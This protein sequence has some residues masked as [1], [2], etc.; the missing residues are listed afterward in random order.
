[1]EKREATGYILGISCFYHDAAAC[2][3][4]DGEIIA[5]AS[6]ERFTRVKHDE[7]F[8]EKA[9]QFCLDF[10]G[11]KQQD[12]DYVCF[13]E[14]PILK[15]ERL[16]E[17]YIKV[18][19]RGLM[20][21]LSAM[22]M[23]LSKKLWI[24]NIFREKMKD[25][26][27]DI[28][29]VPHHL[30]HA[31]AAYYKSGFDDAAVVTL[32]AVGE[33]STTTIGRGVGNKLKI[34][35]E[36]IFPDSLGLFYSA[37]TYYLGFKVN[38]AE[39][40]VMGLA[41]YGKPIYVDKIKELIEIFED[42]SFKL[43]MDYFAYEYDLVMINEKKFKEHFGY[44]TRKD[45]EQLEQFHKDVAASLQKVTEEIVLKIV[46]YAHGLYKT[47]NLCLSGGVALN[48]VANGR[49]IR[50]SKF[51]HLFIF[52][53]AGDAGGA[54]G[55]ALYLY[56][57][58]L[59]NEDNKK[60]KNVYVGPAFRNEDIRKFL[61][62][63]E[64]KYGEYNGEELHK[65]VA[66]KLADNRVIGLFQGR[67]EFGPR[68]LGNRSIIADPRVKENWQRV[69]LKIK[70]RE[71]FRPFAPTVMADHLESMFEIDRETPYML[72][73]AQVIVDYLPAV[74]HLDNSARI[75]SVSKEQNESYYKIIEEFYKLTGCPVIINTSFNLRGE[76][77][78][79]SH[80]D[81]FKGFLRTDMDVLVLNN[82]VI[83][84]TENDKEK[85]KER[86]TFEQ[87]G[88]D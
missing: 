75:Q 7:N 52:P 51:K 14:K 33:W 48:C 36:M 15:F 31:A 57:H 19:P 27:G 21:Y 74:T 67:M 47:E 62:E 20:S 58:V 35:K 73:V 11:I 63:N 17:T 44:A 40:K 2:L 60:L 64:V 1:M 29:Y 5:A 26:K 66:G 87:F 9:M 86:F 30:S 3:L 50:E 23:W 45:D 79:C 55:C 6:E 77:I 69:N 10:A 49:I 43:D 4:K 32:D 80:E 42:G 78:V 34:D 56:H 82:F 12:L 65:V 70:F 39:Y 38:S 85:L 72:L 68:A 25:Y 41:P 18:W 8:P 13:Y 53:E 28:L 54:V 37:F 46:D 61:N 88:K 24:N 84:V 83:D 59:G 76:P 16:L 81:A 22:R 71:S